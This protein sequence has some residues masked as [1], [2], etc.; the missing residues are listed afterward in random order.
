[1]D[2]DDGGRAQAERQRVLEVDEGRPQP[3]EQAREGDGHAQVLRGGGEDDRLDARRYEVGA[4]GDGGEAE[5][6]G[7]GGGRQ[8]AQEVR[9]VRLVAGA[10]AAEHVGVDHD[11]GAGSAAPAGAGARADR[12]TGRAHASASR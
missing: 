3:G 7:A 9:H 12:A 10:V 11:E 5:A 8:G 2:G 4:A 1:M 6:P